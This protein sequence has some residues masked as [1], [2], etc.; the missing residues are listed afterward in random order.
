MPKDREPLNARLVLKATPPRG[1]KT[2]LARP[3]LSL[4]S[5]QL[6][7]K[8]VI[9]VCASPGFG[10]TALLTQWRRE[11]IALGTTVAWLNVDQ[12]D[13]YPAARRRLFDTITDN[14][15]D[16]VVVLTGDIH[17]GG[18]AELV[19]GIER[20]FAGVAGDWSAA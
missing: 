6:A 12:W 11:A 9:A 4:A 2:L 1:R 16:N 7:E 8:S 13:G 18:A 3:R 20:H 14:G 17:A 19:A 10:K 5:E 15:I